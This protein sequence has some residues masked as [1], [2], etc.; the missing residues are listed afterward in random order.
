MNDP[1]NIGIDITKDMFTYMVM[2]DPEKNEMYLCFWR[3]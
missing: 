1:S 2:T 3:N